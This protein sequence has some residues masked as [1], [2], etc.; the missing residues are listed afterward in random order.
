MENKY[1]Q[2]SKQQTR[3]HNTNILLYVIAMHAIINKI[4]RYIRMSYLEN[5]KQQISKAGKG[6]SI[7]QKKIVITRRMQ[8]DRVKLPASL[9]GCHK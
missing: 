4:I 6:V 5:R 7:P 2:A 1:K 3:T 9:K 8:P